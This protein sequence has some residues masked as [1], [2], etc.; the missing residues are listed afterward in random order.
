M[1][2]PAIVAAAQ[3]SHKKYYPLGPYSS[4]SIAQFGIESA[5]G[6]VQ[7]GKNNY[8]G[9]KAT[10]IQIHLGQATTRWTHEFYNGAYHVVEQY[11]ADYPDEQGSFDAHARL[12][13]TSPIYVE[14]Q[15]AATVND[16]IVAMAKHYATAPNYAHV[17]LSV[18]AGS[19]LTQYDME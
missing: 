8:F 19:N 10:P 18:I 4:V 15:R 14:A 12:L 1:I 3:A 7:S 2:P 6:R 9:I 16:Y 5:W 17:I 13:A 11:F